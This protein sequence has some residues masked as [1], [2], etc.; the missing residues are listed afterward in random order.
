MKCLHLKIVYQIDFS[1]NKCGAVE[2]KNQRREILS[3]R[4][5]L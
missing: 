5:K 2:K 4:L 1:F 3:L